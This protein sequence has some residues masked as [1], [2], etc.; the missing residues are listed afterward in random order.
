[1]LANRFL[2]LIELGFWRLIV[3]SLHFS[4]HFADLIQK[5]KGGIEMGPGQKKSFGLQLFW[6]LSAWF[7]GTAISFYLF[8]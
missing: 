8:S 2:K 5:Q 3:G 4:K 6:A 1:M 7:I